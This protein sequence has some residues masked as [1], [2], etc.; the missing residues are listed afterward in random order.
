M[1]HYSE[2]GFL[3]IGTGEDVTISKFAELVA[4]VVGYG[5]KIIYDSSRPD[6]A[7]RKLLDVSKIKK[8]GWA[9]KTKL[10]DGLAQTYA[11]FLVTGGRGAA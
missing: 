7:P 10:R 1:K 11:D 9:A 5:G 4:E 6:G 2:I 8:L 3:N